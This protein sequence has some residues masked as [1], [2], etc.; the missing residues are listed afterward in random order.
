MSFFDCVQNAMDG[1]EADRDRGKRAQAMWEDRRERYKTMGYDDH[2]ADI[3]AG[4]DVKAAFKKEA[5]DTRHVFLA[6]INNM[7]KLQ[8]K[9]NSATPDD[10]PFLQTRSVEELDYKA[11][12]LVRRFNG[13]LG[14]FLKEHH[15]DI[16]GRVKNPA[17]M[18]NIVKE[19]HGE[20]TGDAAASAFAKGIGEALEDMR[21]MFNEAGGVIGKLDAW[22]LPHTHNRR[23]VTRATF[24][25]WFE[26]IRQ[27]INWKVT[28]DHLTGKPFQDAAGPAPSLETQRSFLKGIYDNIAYGEGS[29]EAVYGR[30]SGKALYRRRAESRVLHFKNAEGWVNYN[31][32]YGTGDAYRTL[33]SHVHKMARDIVSLREFGPN[34]NLG[35]E[36]QQQL[37]NKR[38][39]DL[40]LERTKLKDYEGNGHHA[41]RMMK[42]EQGGA[43]PQ[44][45]MQD[46]VSTFLSSA[47]H[48]MTAA[49]LDRAIVASLSDL[50]TIR[51]AASAVGMNPE[52]V[53]KRHVELLAS[54]MARDEALRAGWIADTLADPGVALARFQSEVP[55]AEIAE[56]LSSASM[57][58]QG[59][60]GWTDQARIAFQFEMAGHMASFAGRKL[61]DVDEPLRGM[62]LRRGITEDDWARF[63]DAG[64]LFKAGNGATF[65]SPHYWRASTD[66]PFDKAED[67][68]FKFQGLIEEQT[69]YAVPTQ[70]LLARGMVDPAAYGVPPG[71]I[72]YEVVKSGLMFKSF[73][74]TFTVNQ[75][76]RIAAQPTAAGKIG[77]GL[78]LAAGATV[79]GVIA[80]QLG[81]VIKGNDPADM[82]NPTFWGKAMLKGGGFGI[83]GDIVATGESSWG[84]GFASYAAGPVPQAMNDVWGL[85]IG[86]ALE[87]AMGED[88]KMAAELSRFGKRYTPMGQTPLVGP[89]MDRLLWDQLQLFLDPDSEREMVRRATNTNNLNGTDGWWMPG[90]AVPER[91]PNLLNAIGQ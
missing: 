66:L 50:N 25:N 57:R 56:R 8:L 26:D 78:N 48:V 68:F 72:A 35:V 84:G 13:R 37:V 32:K 18:L 9:V 80:L 16:L 63:T 59:L 34:P 49:F 19:M 20:A 47:R 1:D 5:G 7:R 51:L 65:A 22:G 87:F 33:M 61:K 81:E 45:L 43:A 30:P 69:E 55:P 17:E 64:A 85:T 74:M 4:E 3:L 91:A 12:G 38:A 28:T 24:D 42:V 27:D 83:V 90:S 40:G 86:N 39:R 36:Y 60:S 21:V 15:R 62:L 10:L 44:S 89:A 14:A 46:Y 73:T 82:S 58:I 77:Y 76:R 52:N 29:K 11:R 2:N 6:K 70:S 75:I 53:I 31:K 23:A 41:V 88:T 79:M 67:I 71:T 54:G